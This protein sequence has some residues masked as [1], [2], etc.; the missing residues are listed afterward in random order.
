M[1]HCISVEQWYDHSVWSSRVWSHHETFIE[2]ECVSEQ[3]KGQSGR[4]SV[5]E[6]IVEHVREATFTLE[7][8]EGKLKKLT[9]TT[10]SEPFCQIGL[11]PEMV[12]RGGRTNSTRRSSEAQVKTP[13]TASDRP[14]RLEAVQNY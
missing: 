13:N 4:P 9:N 14:R 3:H 12:Q 2:A 7:A 6:D 5:S 10:H 1:R 11:R 8:P